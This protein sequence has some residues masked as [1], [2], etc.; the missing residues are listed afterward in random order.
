[1]AALAFGE[2][3]AILFFGTFLP[4]DVEPLPPEQVL[5]AMPDD[6]ELMAYQD[7]RGVSE[8][9]D[10]Q[11]EL[12]S[13]QSWIA[14][15]R[16][17]AEGLSEINSMIG[18][19]RTELAGTLG[20]DPFT[21]LNAASICFKLNTTSGAPKPEVLILVQG[22]FDATVADTIAGMI[23]MGRTT[24]SNGVEVFA[25]REDGVVFGL[26]GVEGAFVFASESYLVPLTT[27]FPAPGVPTAAPGSLLARLADLAPGGIRTYIA[28]RPATSTRLLASAEGP[29]SFA[30]LVVGLESALIVMNNDSSYT[31]IVASDDTSHRNYELILGGIGDLMQASPLAISGMAQLFFG[32]LSP[33]DNDIEEDIRTILAHRDEILG[34]IEELG[35]TQ[36]AEVVFNSDLGTRTTSLTTTGAGGAQATGALMLM[37][38]GSAFFLMRSGND[39]SAYPPAYA[40]P[41]YYYEEEVAPT[42]PTEVPVEVAPE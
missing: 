39:E 23:G 4:S 1:M 21:D 9:I 34:L 35:L 36:P 8:A 20:F 42:V 24:L 16:E 41:G 10:A 33:D 12:L 37:G 31:E 14:S 29:V 25:E 15:N 22:N 11:L 3:F 38:V 2:I 17:F 18:S 28:G 7:F 30:K 13:R 27:A 26:Y 40:D 5:W 6:C 19:A 32:I